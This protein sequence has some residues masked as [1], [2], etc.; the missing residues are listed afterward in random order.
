MGSDT[1]RPRFAPTSVSDFSDKSCVIVACVPCKY[2]SIYHSFLVLRFHHSHGMQCCCDIVPA[3]ALA[4]P[5]AA[6]LCA[7]PTRAEHKN[8][9]G[10]LVG[11]A[12][13]AFQLLIR[14][15]VV[16]SRYELLPWDAWWP[17][18]SINWTIA[19]KNHP[20]R[21]RWNDR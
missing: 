3:G 15:G 17:S 2:N 4:A 19:S 6:C 8:A 18:N 14:C 21:R 12:E 11:P 9:V 20:K 7:L 1:I 16:F 5:L 10:S 13:P